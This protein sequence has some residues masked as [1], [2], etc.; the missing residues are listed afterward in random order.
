MFESTGGAC[1]TTVTTNI[2]LMFRIHHIILSIIY[3][4]VNVRSIFVFDAYMAL[5]SNA[6]LI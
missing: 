6:K 1:V 2:S 3:N 4:V 5:I